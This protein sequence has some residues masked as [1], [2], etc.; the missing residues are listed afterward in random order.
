MKDIN[1]DKVWVTDTEVWIHTT[2]GR[3][4]KSVV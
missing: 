4:R 3:D 2:D 1:V